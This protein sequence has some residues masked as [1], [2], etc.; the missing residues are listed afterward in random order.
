[1][2]F[3]GG[4]FL[5]SYPRTDDKIEFMDNELFESGTPLDLMLRGFHRDAVKE[6][7]GVDIGY[8]GASLKQQAKGIDRHAYKVSHVSNRVAVSVIDDVLAAYA[9]GASKEATLASLGLAGVNI[10][11]LKKLF[12]DIGYGV[13][14]QRADTA[15]R[16]SQM[17]AGMQA[18]HGVDNPFKLDKFQSKAG[19]TREQRYGGR[20]TLSNGSSLAQGARENFAEKMLVSEVIAQKSLFPEGS[21]A[22]LICRGFKKKDIPPNCG[23]AYDRKSMCGVDRHWY[24]GKH[25][26]TRYAPECIDIFVSDY[27]DGLASRA[28]FSTVF[29][30]GTKLSMRKIFESMGLLDEYRAAYRIRAATIHKNK[31][32]VTNR[33]RYGGDSPMASPNVVNKQKDSMVKKYG[34]ANASQVEFVKEKKRATSFYNYGVSHPMQSSVVQSR[35][36]NSVRDRYG[37][38]NVSQADAIKVKKAN[39]SFYNYGASSYLLTPECQTSLVSSL[40]EKYGE[41]MVDLAMRTFNVTSEQLKPFHLVGVLDHAI[42]RVVSIYGAP[43]VFNLDVVQDQIRDNLMR[44][45]GVSNVSQ[46]PGVKVKRELTMLGLYGVI[47]VFMDPHVQDK[48][49]RGNVIKYGFENPAKSDVVKKK[50]ALTK[51]RNGTFAA[52]NTEETLYSLLVDAFGENNV[53]R[54][55]SDRERYPFACDFYVP[56]RDL[57][58][59]LN[60]TWTHG[61]R[62]YEGSEVDQQQVD[63]WQKKDTVYFDNALYNWTVRDVAKREAAQRHNLNYV[64]FW[65]GSEALTDATL[66]IAMGCPDGTD[67]QKMYSWLPQ[68]TL[69]ASGFVFPEVSDLREFAKRPV[70]R[71]AVKAANAETFYAREIA[72]WNNNTPVRLSH[73]GTPQA[74]L[75]ANRYKYLGKLPEQL[76]DAE[77]FR[78][79][80]ISGALRSYST[81]DAAAMKQVLATYNSRRVYDPCAGWGERMLTCAA[82]GVAYMGVDINPAVIEGHRQ[83]VHTYGLTEQSTRVGNAETTDMRSGS[84]DMVFTC[85]PYG[86]TEIYTEQGAENLD[87]QGFLSW[88]SKV[89]EMAVSN[90]TEV[91]AYQINQAWKQRMNAVVESHGWVLTEQ[92]ALGITASHMQ[93]KKS[94]KNKGKSNRR[95]FEEV[96][97][98]VRA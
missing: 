66:W 9:G 39:T 6:M 12:A 98:F 44:D 16:S 54:Q 79:M 49:K 36:R 31:T 14:F 8:N 83:L 40:R 38:D 13:D 43:N 89:V 48:I 95:E 33:S 84:H 76:S 20:Y 46:L 74:R 5:L 86:D 72:I 77:L 69:D 24:A 94:G 82:L 25:V 29:S 62:W 56:S 52:S 91:F 53:V 68:R 97:V 23:F 92:V 80:G 27:G 85:P 7:T 17:T 73:W 45:Y 96:Q 71:Q 3:G 42:S 90:S 87:E 18:A 61:G 11:K 58:I 75:Y 1:M 19:D 21:E 10:V 26:S 34:V 2:F 35:L 65:D 51:R 47:N 64:V 4:S 78:G 63:K 55:Y 57:F 93:R 67:W 50:V 22:D 37:V 28:D 15:R 59:E 60:G 81:F 70:L 88:W 41:D 30:V 32:A